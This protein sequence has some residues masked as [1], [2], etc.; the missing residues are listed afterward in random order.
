[1]QS[2][3]TRHWAQQA[4]AKGHHGGTCHA[5]RRIPASSAPQYMLWMMICEITPVAIATSM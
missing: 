2:V 3:M 4:M 1:M 5:Q